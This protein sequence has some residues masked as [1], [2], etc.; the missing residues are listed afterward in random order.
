[1]IK[2]NNNSNL[3]FAGGYKNNNGTGSQIK[4]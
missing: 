2:Q 1:M 4:K 3:K